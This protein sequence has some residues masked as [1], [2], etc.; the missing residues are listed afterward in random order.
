MIDRFR[1]TRLLGYRPYS[2]YRY[3]HSLILDYRVQ[4]TVAYRYTSILIIELTTE[5]SL[6][7]GVD[8]EQ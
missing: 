3:K 2:L 1:C 6:D 7:E 4:D 5:H 8:R